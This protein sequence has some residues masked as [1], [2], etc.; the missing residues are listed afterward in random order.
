MKAG[1][2]GSLLS[3]KKNKTPLSSRS[4]RQRKGIILAMWSDSKQSQIF[5]RHSRVVRVTFFTIFY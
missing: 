5:F 3:N 2:A 1:A 4:K